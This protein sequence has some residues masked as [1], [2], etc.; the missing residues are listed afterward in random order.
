[1]AY[2][3]ETEDNRSA[4]LRIFAGSFVRMV[5]QNGQESLK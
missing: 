5:G 3:L 2:Y 1:M 4:W